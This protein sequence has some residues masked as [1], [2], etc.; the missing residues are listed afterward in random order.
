MRER[1]TLCNQWGTEK[2]SD[3]GGD[4]SPKV[5]KILQEFGDLFHSPTG[6]PPPRKQDQAINLKEGAGIP[7]IRPYRY[8]HYLKNEIEKIIEE[9]LKARII[10]PSMSPYSSFGYFG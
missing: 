5:N 3:S 6:L 4:N 7:H 10:R 9:L 2:N 1:V 8:P